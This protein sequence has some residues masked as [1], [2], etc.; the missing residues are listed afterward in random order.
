VLLEN[1]GAPTINAR[2]RQQQAPWEV[3][4]EDLE[5]HTINHLENVDGAPL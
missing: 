5:V 4:P 1:P 3:L 2:K